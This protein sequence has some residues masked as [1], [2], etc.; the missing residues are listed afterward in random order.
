MK[1]VNKQIEENVVRVTTERSAKCN[2]NRKTQAG[3]FANVSGKLA[4]LLRKQLESWEGQV[5]MLSE[6]LCPL[7]L[8][9]S[10][11]IH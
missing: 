9:D 2:R 10:I 11:V 7:L 8:A 1:K 4:L 3:G 5:F 6:Y